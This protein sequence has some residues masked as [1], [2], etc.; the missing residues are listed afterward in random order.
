MVSSQAAATRVAAMDVAREYG[1]PA[2]A[3]SIHGMPPALMN[4]RAQNRH[5]QAAGRA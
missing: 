5:D 2:D 3:G 4:V 1:W